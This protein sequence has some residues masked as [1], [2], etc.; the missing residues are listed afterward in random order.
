MKK[1]VLILSIAIGISIISCNGRKNISGGPCS[2]QTIYYPATIIEI[3]N[4]D[5][6]TNE[7]FFRVDY[8]GINHYDTLWYSLAF[9]DFI[10]T[11]ELEKQNLKVG[12]V[13][14]YEH[15]KI[16]SGSCNPDIYRLTLNK[17]ESTE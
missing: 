3:E 1:R 2:Y 17:F 13:V 6:L 11:A 4:A 14:K 15:R 8:G 9:G 7:V 5:S 16:I 12:D 10:S